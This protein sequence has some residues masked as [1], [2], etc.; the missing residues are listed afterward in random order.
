VA[1]EDALDNA[2]SDRF[3]SQ[4]AGVQWLLG[5]PDASGGSQAS[6]M[7]WHHCSG[8]KA[9]DVPSRGASCKRSGTVQ[10]WGASQC[11]R[12]RQTVRRLVHALRVTKVH[13]QHCAY[14]QGRKT[15]P[16]SAVVL[17]II[18]AY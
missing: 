17:I 5:H 12:P 9:S 14:K 1:L 8:L 11:W 2:A 10:G 13:A 15:T 7:I 16:P 3:I 6:A 18:K 4:L